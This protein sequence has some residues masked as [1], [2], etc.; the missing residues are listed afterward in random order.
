MVLFSL[1]PATALAIVADAV[2]LERVGEWSGDGTCTDAER[3]ACDD[4][5]GEDEVAANGIDDDCDGT[6]DEAQDTPGDSG[7]ADSGEAPNSGDDAEPGKASVVGPGP[8]C[9]CDA[10]S[11]APPFGARVGAGALAVALARRR[12][13]RDVPV[14]GGDIQ[15]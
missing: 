6:V 13:V 4:C 10:G 5:P 12:R 3:C 1:L 14:A 2:K 11:A 8:R 7:K 15:C 9:A